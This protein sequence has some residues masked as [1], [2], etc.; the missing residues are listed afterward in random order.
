[1]TYVY[2]NEQVRDLLI[3]M[4]SEIDYYQPALDVLVD[5]NVI[6]VVSFQ[7]EDRNSRPLAYEE[8]N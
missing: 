1:M 2:T 8:G 4:H 7:T 3:H 5:R 6:E